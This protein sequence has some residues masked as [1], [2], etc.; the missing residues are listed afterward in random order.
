MVTD[1]TSQLQRDEGIRLYPYL[2]TVG[3]V[4]IGVGRNLTD[5]GISRT[6]CDAMLRNDIE[7][8]DGMLMEALPWA[9][10][11]DD[12]RHGVLLN[13]TFNMG[14]TGL[15]GF[16]DTLGKIQTRDYDGA[17]DSM[18]Q[19]KWATQVGARAQR[20]AQQLRTGVWQ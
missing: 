12:A 13:M 19:S 1:I 17:A 4:T 16:R 9:E 3:K 7:R 2:D 10:G 6:E 8:A 14:V 15:L 5:V 11:L 20:L 18:L